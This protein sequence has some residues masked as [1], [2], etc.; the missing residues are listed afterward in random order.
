MAKI[1]LVDDDKDLIELIKIPL[2]I[3]GYQTLVVYDGQEGYQKACEEKPDLILLDLMLPKM[4]GYR[5]CQKL[6]SDEKY[7]KIPV[8]MLTARTQDLER[9]MAKEL[10]ADAYFM[11]PF[12]LKL[13]L[14]KIQEL[15]KE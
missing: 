3:K 5:V 11:K 15:L 13:L 1:L 2:E 9:I 7:K 8:I 6:K 14:A 10:G 4:D 12:E